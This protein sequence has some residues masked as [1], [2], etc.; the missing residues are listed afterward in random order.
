MRDPD[1]FDAFYKDARDRLL[2]QTFCFT[3]DLAVARR[4]VRDAFVVA[5]HRW[6]KVSRLDDPE[7][8]VRPDAWRIA[9]RRHTTRVWHRERDL[10]D[11]VRATLEA[12]GKLSVHQR[13]AVLL[14]QL[15]AVSMPQMAREIGLPLDRAEQ[16]LQAGVAQLSLQRDVASSAVPTLLEPVAQAALADPQWPRATI[17]R[18]AGATRRRT[19]TLVGVAGAV[20]AVLVSGSL[21]TDAGGVRASLDRVAEAGPPA[22]AGPDRAVSGTPAMRLT[23]T[24]LVDDATLSSRF[25]GRAWEEVRTGDNSAGTGRAVPCQGDRYADPR[26]D[27]ALVRTSQAPA[28]GR[29]PAL[30]AVQLTEASPR[31]PAAE[32]A[33]DTAVGW[34]S[35]CAL[36]S[37]QLLDTTTPVGVGDEAVHLVL[38]SSAARSPQTWLVGVART[39]VF[40]TTT[41]VRATGDP[42]PDAVRSAGLLADAV[43]RLCGLD[44][45]GASCRPVTGQAAPRLRPRDPL[46]AGTVPALLSEID[47]APVP[48]VEQPWVGTE[49][50]RL[51]S[52][53]AT[54]PCGPPPFTER[55]RG[56][57]FRKGATRSFVVPRSRLPQE[58]GL[59][60]NVAALPQRTARRFLDRV[61]ERFASCPDRELG[62]DVDR[63]ASADRGRRAYTVWRLDVRVTEQRSIAY[64]VVALRNGTA[65]GQLDLVPADVRIGDREVVALA[66]R[67]VARLGSLSGAG[68]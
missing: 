32:R 43:G 4:A 18:R 62:T 15:A 38:R 7:T 40:T 9:Q 44:G 36:P 68:S 37:V 54:T 52:A 20:A 46:P 24:T 13:K 57:P 1:Q 10:D 31:V 56:T 59:T 14:T 25:P 50:R 26:G 35:G 49:P 19:H 12:L 66:E 47:L 53:A 51:Q 27:A 42:A 65:V 21:V 17:I 5:W 41:F 23:E 3:G 45:A 60:E 2:V 29:R 16:E 48:R 55:F 63:I 6:R 33:F 34:F 61:R 64:W 22:A 28:V 39:G 11:D 58:F 8:V 30:R 67:A